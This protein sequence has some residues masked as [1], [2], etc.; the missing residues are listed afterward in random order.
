MQ[1]AP[2]LQLTYC[3]NIH[4]ANG[5]AAVLEN[6]R[7]YALP[8]KAALAPDRPFAL[9]LRLSGAESRELLEADRLA[10]FA[11]FLEEHGLAIGLLNGF[12]YG[13]FHRQPVKA[14]VHAP[15]WRTSE[16][17]AY[18]KRL[19]RI[20]AH[21]LPDG[22]GGG[23]S[24][25]PLSYKPWFGNRVG[26]AAWEAFTRNV[27][28][29]AGALVE[30]RR[31]SGKTLHLDIE[32]EPDGVIET[33]AGMV[34]FFED[35]L[36][37]RGVP[38]LA[39]AIGCAPSEA[40]AMLREHVRVCWDTCH[41]AVAYEEPAEVLARYEAAGLQVGRVQVS[42]ALEVP[43]P[44]DPD[45]ASRAGQA[46]RA[47]VADALAPFAE[48]VYLHQVI[49]K[50]RDGRLRAYPDLDAALPHIGDPEAAAWRIHFHVPIFAEDFGLFGST[51]AGILQ[52]LELLH[53]RP[54]TRHLEIET[55][56]WDVLPPRLKRPLAE[57]TRR[58]FTWVMETLALLPRHA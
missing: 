13:P 19:I 28:D 53:E 50:N 54:F 21:L 16:R 2:D 52:T 27:A 8:L 20:L 3:T 58:E 51:Q 17:V 56:T 6:L 11:D 9:G 1:I 5:W 38:M 55:Y 10:R 26:E 48:S 15:D 40:E 46:A 39:G 34:G 12:P 25:N 29:V 33:S 36:L 41:V 14:D 4:P 30:A 49:Q 7:R 57:M 42:S 24:T 47:R 45:P 22:A 43:L 37:R 18:T 32:P 44:S 35:H 23:I 31:T